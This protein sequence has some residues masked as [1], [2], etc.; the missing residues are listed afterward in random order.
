MIPSTLTNYHVKKTSYYPSGPEQNALFATDTE[1][2]T[3][4]RI[5]WC[6]NGQHSH[7]VLTNVNDPEQRGYYVFIH[8]PV[9]PL[10][11][12]IY[13]KEMELIYKMPKNKVKCS[14]D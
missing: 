10:F 8:R 2:N 6:G 9:T 14:Y 13:Y 7:Y 3:L 4:Y 12:E 5:D 11:K 1:T